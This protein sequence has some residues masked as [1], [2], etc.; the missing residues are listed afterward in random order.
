[1]YLNNYQHL[2]NNETYFFIFLFLFSLLIR[3]PVILLFGDTSLV[4]EWENLVHNLI[5]H[6]KLAYDLDGFLLPNLY[7]PPLY[8]YYLYFFSFFNLE[9]KNYIILILSSQILLASIS[10]VVFYKINKLFFSQKISFY[11]SLMFSLFPLH[12]Y[13][14]SQISSISLQMFLAIFYL[15]FF[16]QFVKKKNLSS[17]VI[18]SFLSG[19]L[20]LLRGEFRIIFVLS[21][22][23]LFFFFKISNVLITSGF[24]FT[25]LV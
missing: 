16:F 12:M 22:L 14:C 19:L 7:M 4:N 3:L 5:T 20:I 13:A 21:L 23:Y 17:I 15:Y 18:F 2:E 1:M 8:A 11:S 10:V 24:N 6:G 9:N 25:K